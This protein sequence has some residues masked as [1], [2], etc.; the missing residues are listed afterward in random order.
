MRPKLPPTT[1]CISRPKKKSV[2][3]KRPTVSGEQMT[4]APLPIFCGVLAAGDDS[5]KTRICGSFAAA[6]SCSLDGERERSP[7][8][9]RIELYLPAAIGAWGDGFFLLSEAHGDFFVRIRPAP[10]GRRHIALE[11][12]V[13]G[14]DGG[15][16]HIGAREGSHREEESGRA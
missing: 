7:W 4:Q 9:E 16:L 1:F 15:E 5:V 8:L 10:D 2:A 14:D 12:H 3:E 11:H 6:F 13:L